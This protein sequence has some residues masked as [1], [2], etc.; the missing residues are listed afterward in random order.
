MYIKRTLKIQIG[1]DFTKLDTLLRFLKAN[2][3]Q[4]HLHEL[5]KQTRF[6][7]G[8]LKKYYPT[9]H[10]MINKMWTDIL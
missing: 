1:K 7:D 9:D 5:Q 8:F 2:V 6:D 4:T 10:E 3:I